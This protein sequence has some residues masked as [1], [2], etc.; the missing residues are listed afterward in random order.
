MYNDILAQPVP[1]RFLD[2]LKDIDAMGL[3]RRDGQGGLQAG[4]QAGIQ[5][6]VL[7]KQTGVQAGHLDKKVA[8]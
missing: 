2:L 7:D 3:P 5:T 8:K 4:V 6:G 1:D